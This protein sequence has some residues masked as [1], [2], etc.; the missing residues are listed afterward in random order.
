MRYD[1][2]FFFFSAHLL[3]DGMDRVSS[4]CQMYLGL[5]ADLSCYFL[6]PCNNANVKSLHELEDALTLISIF[7]CILV[8]SVFV[9]FRVGL[10]GSFCKIKVGSC[11]T[12]LF[13][14]K[15]NITC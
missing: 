15:G 12:L 4:V 11:L 7:L 1:F 10:V 3:L 2:D 5:Y 9:S 8:N 13:T 6:S 14:Q